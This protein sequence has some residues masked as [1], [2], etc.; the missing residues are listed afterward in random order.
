MSTVTT[1]EKDSINMR[2]YGIDE[3]YLGQ[4]ASFTKTVTETDVNNFA[5]L[6]GDFNP[7]HVNAEY[8]K[9][10]RFGERIA[11]GMLTASYISTCLA[12]GI[13]GADDIFLGINLKFLGAVKLGDTIRVEVEIIDINVQKQ[14]L[15]LKA[16]ITNQKGEVVVEG[17]TKNMIGKT[18][19]KN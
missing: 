7:A 16:T 18:K 11:H 15:T 14:I 19:K 2:P 1:L 8:A 5:C 6:I 9:T 4:K 17:E 13:P 10:T 12:M 3:F